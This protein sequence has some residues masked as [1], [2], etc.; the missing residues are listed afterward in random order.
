VF[1]VD[2]KQCESWNVIISENFNNIVLNIFFRFEQQ[3]TATMSLESIQALFMKTKLKEKDTLLSIASHKLINMYQI[4]KKDFAQLKAIKLSDINDE[5][6][7]FFLIVVLYV[8]KES[9]KD[10]KESLKIVL[11]LMFRTDHVIIYKNFI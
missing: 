1:I 7:S 10:V 3:M 5:F 9:E 4:Y 2:F 11:I 6:L 8:K